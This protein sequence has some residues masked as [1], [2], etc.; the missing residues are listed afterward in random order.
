MART[1]TEDTMTGYRGTAKAHRTNGTNLSAPFIYGGTDI[2]APVTDG[3]DYSGVCGKRFERIEIGRVGI[4]AIDAD[5]R[6]MCIGGVATRFWMLP[7][8]AEAAAPES[9]DLD[10]LTFP[11]LMEI[12]K[13]IK[14]KGRGVA[15]RPQLIEGIR[16][17]RAAQVS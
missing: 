1:P 9:D 7:V 16:A 15:R 6:E 4:C 2:K 13:A 10:A 3:S 12:A 11:K 5:G 17:H 8:P 14:L